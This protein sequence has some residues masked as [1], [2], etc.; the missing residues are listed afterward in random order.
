MGRKKS[1]AEIEIEKGGDKNDPYAEENDLI[2]KLLIKK[3]DPSLHVVKF[4]KEDS[5]IENN[6]SHLVCDYPD[7]PKPV[8]EHICIPIGSHISVPMPIKD[9]LGLLNSKNDTDLQRFIDNPIDNDNLVSV[10]RGNKPSQKLLNVIMEEIAE[11]AAYLKA[12]RNLNWEGGKD[13]SDTT[14]KRIKMLKHLVE[15]LVEK[16]KLKKED[17]IGKIDFHGEAFQRVLRYFLETIQRTI[18]KINIPVQYEDIF[19]T[20]LAKEFD[21]FEKSAEKLYYG[22][23]LK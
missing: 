1:Y 8:E 15:T 19:F 17:N 14:F 3:G 23:D 10:V 9:T 22:K 6:F 18:K 12:W 2:E 7:V 11:E 4:K 16:E 5:D 13:L 21:G 20:E